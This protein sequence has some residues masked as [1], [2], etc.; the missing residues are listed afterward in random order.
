MKRR[1]A[2]ALIALTLFA[3][4]A[5]AGTMNEIEVQPLPLGS[6]K[7][8]QFINARVLAAGVAETHTFATGCAYVFFA[9]DGDWYARWD[10]SAA[11]VPAADVTDG[12]A[13]ELN[14]TLRYVVG[15]AT[16]SMIAPVATIITISCYK[17]TR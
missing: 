16:V 1:F 8:A 13:S 12:T 6:F 17:W 7:P 15:Q 4:S 3:A 2:A 9:S 14:P 5:L 11:A 10:G